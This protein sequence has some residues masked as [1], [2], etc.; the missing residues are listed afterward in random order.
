M[1]LLTGCLETEIDPQP[2]MTRAALGAVELTAPRGYC[3]DEGSLRRIGG[4]GG[5]ALVASCESLTGTPGLAVDPALMTVSV[6]AR[7][8][9][10]QAPVAARLAAA[11]APA[12]VGATG[13]ADGLAYA[14]V[15]EGGETILPG[16]DP[17][18]W[19]GARVV[20]DRL[21]GLAVYAPADSPLGRG[22]AEGRRLLSAL[23]AGLAARFPDTAGDTAQID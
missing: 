20:G 2:E 12:P 13:E 14:Q 21:V 16:G 3:I 10:A 18:H 9:P 15:L 8:A 1:V 5:F 7:D 17:K 23:A 6:L 22:G 11:V 19:R 4:G